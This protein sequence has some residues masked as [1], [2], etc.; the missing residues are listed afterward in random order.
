MTP[1]QRG[2]YSDYETRVDDLGIVVRFP[3]GARYSSLSKTSHRFRGPP[4]TLYNG[5]QR[6]LPQRYSGRGA[7]VHSP[8]SSPKFISEW[9]AI[10]QFFLVFLYGVQRDK[11][12]FFFNF[13]LCLSVSLSTIT[14]GTSA[15][16]T[17]RSQPN[18]TDK[19]K[20]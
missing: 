11:T 1:R 18:I 2:W 16:V 19:F 15:V 13:I 20:I 5:H 8:P 14:E 10:Y 9:T 6:L 3:I 7:A 17:R 12:V 4:S